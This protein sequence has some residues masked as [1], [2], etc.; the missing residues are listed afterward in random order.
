MTVKVW[1][2]GVCTVNSLWLALT[3]CAAPT[4]NPNGGG[5]AQPPG[6]LRERDAV[7]RRE[8][9]GEIGLNDGVEPGVDEEPQG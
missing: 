5:F 9:R 8:I 1:P 6:Q 7:G 3:L 4:R 2:E